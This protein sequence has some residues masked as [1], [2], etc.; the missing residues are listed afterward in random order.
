MAVDATGDGVPDASTDLGFMV[1]CPYVQ[2]WPLGSAD[3]DAD[4]DGE[5]IVTTGFSIMDQ[6][7]FSISE[8]DGGSRD[9]THPPR[10]ARPRRE[11]HRAR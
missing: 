7:Y 5:L 8:G 11:W 3:F 2:C 9:R 4:G 6:G 10:G 1:N